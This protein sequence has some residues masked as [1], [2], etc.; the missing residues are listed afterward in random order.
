MKIFVT[1][2]ISIILFVTAVSFGSLQISA[3][4]ANELHQLFDKEWQARMERFP[5]WAESMGDK[6]RADQ[7]SDV[8]ESA[9]Q[10]WLKIT[11]QFL[12]QLDKIEFKLLTKTDKIN[13][14][15]F[16]QQ[17]VNRQS[18]LVFKDYQI[19]FLAD[20]GFHTSIARL[21]A[22]TEFT[23][24]QDYLAY[25]SRLEKVPNYFKQNIDN[26]NMGLVRN[27]SMPAVVMLGFTD[28]IRQQDKDSLQDSPFFEPFKK[29]PKTLSLSEQKKLIE[30]AR[31]VISEKVLPAYRE[32]ADYFE[33]VYI[34]KTKQSLGALDFPNGKAYYQH[35]ITQ[36]T[37]EKLTPDAIH[38]IGLSEVKRIRK[39]MEAII[40][41][42]KFEGD[43][44]Q[45][46]KFLRESPQFYATTPEQLLK[47]AAYIAKK[48]DGQ[49]PRFFT[50][51]PR[52]PYTVEA[53]PDSI[54]PKYTTGRYV[55]AP[56]SSTRPG[57]YWVNT[58]ALDKRPLYVL[59]SLTLHEAVPGHHLQGALTQELESLPNFRRYSYISA[60]GEGWALY[61]E[62]LGIEAGFYQDPYS[63]FGRLS[64][65]MWRAARLVI[66]T[67]IHA[68]G[69]KREQAI[70]LLE[71]NSALSTHN[72]RTEVD[73]YISWPGQALSYKLGELKIIQLRQMAEEKLADKF[74]IR[75]FHDAILANGSIPLDVLDDQIKD[76]VS[77]QLSE[78]NK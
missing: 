27:F 43:F 40:E 8:S 33:K 39:E 72:I 6:S 41:S 44:K 22:E 52:Q 75:L 9:Q 2:P 62:K 4:P 45:F 20:S 24:K 77:Q 14:Q 38:Q 46:L 65:E 76:F 35:K 53:V 18:Q 69:W 57:T 28:V 11:S 10:R 64:Y 15:I 19:P 31:E 7:L 56:L 21:P 48:M 66:D 26:M 70:A 29:L 5:K 12:E 34:P 54:A 59:E 25:L 60:F 47:E 30:R 13:Y 74:D 17:L 42:L 23:N 78:M 37:T 1:N 67:G 63:D 73:R 50:K 55:S 68:L 36:Y 49:L 3:D 51:L 61:C 16:K 71:E 32:L 58:Y